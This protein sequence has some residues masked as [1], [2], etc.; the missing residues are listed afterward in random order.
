[1]PVEIP[2]ATDVYWASLSFGGPY[3]KSY[4]QAATTGS[5]GLTEQDLR[6]SERK[7][8]H[9][10]WSM[11]RRY[12][13]KA[14]LEGWVAQDVP[15]PVK[16]WADQLAACYALQLGATGG[17]IARKDSYWEDAKKLLQEVKQF[18]EDGEVLVDVENEIIPGLQ[19]PEHSAAGIRGPR[20]S[21]R[22]ATRV[23]NEE[24]LKALVE[25]DSPCPREYVTEEESIE[26]V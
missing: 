19:S 5:K 16:D 8:H 26:D 24:P 14:T 2:P 6:Y 1:M 11:F 23:F 9:R 10:L 18:L 20:V 25:C 12:Y 3:L 4:P 21:T 13:A 15:E 7:A 17:R 22:E